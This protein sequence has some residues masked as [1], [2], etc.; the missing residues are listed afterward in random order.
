M[1]VLR[2]LCLFLFAHPPRRSRVAEN[3]PR[4]KRRFT[5]Y[6][7]GGCRTGADRD[8]GSIILVARIE[9]PLKRNCVPKAISSPQPDSR[10]FMWRTMRA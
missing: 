8:S 4:L 5:A 9:T 3:L 2:T 1:N 10:I 6:A 7:L